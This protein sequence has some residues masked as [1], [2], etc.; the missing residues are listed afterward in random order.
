MDRQNKKTVS[1]SQPKSEKQDGQEEL[2]YD[3][4]DLMIEFIKVE[5]GRNPDADPFISNVDIEEDEIISD[6]V[7]QQVNVRTKRQKMSHKTK[8]NCGDTSGRDRKV[9]SARNQ[10]IATSL[11]SKPVNTSEPATTFTEGSAAEQS[12]TSLFARTEERLTGIEFSLVEINSKLDVLGDQFQSLLESVTTPPEKKRTIIDIGF[13]KID[14][15]EQLETFNEDLSQLEYKEK[16]MQW[17]EG[18]IIEERSEYRM[19]D[20]LDMLFTRRFLTLCSWTGIGKG[21]QKIAMMQMTNVTKLFQRIGTTLTA[22]VNHKRVAVFFMKKLK[23]ASKRAVVKGV[24][25]NS[26]PAS[27]SNMEC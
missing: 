10:A 13:D 20:A 3:S 6:Q 22:I 14:N 26:S 12:V 4:E 25:T 23:N 19:T 21:T 7:I 27:S 2:D 1:A 11:K 18:N 8:H 15:L 9:P 16:I 5:C 17:L 24:R